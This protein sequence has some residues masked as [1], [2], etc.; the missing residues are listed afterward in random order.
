MSSDR[1]GAPERVGSDPT[2]TGALDGVRV[3]EATNGVAGS[4]AGML[5][6]DH[7]A[8]VLALRTAGRG[9]S[10]SE[11]GLH[12]WDRNKRAALLDP[13]A[14]GDLEALDPLVAAADIVLIGTTEPA[15]T[16][17]QLRDRGLSPGA[18]CWVVMPPYLLGETPW[19]GE[20]ESA[21][22]LFAGLGQAWSQASYD[23]RPVDCLYPL[24]LHMQ[25]VWAATVA[26]AT[27]V[28]ARAGRPVGHLAVVGGAHG[29]LLA[30]PG[31]FSVG[32]DDPHVHRPSGPGGALPNYRCY[33]CADGGWVFFGAFTTAFMQRGFAAI[34]AGPVLADPRVGGDP[35]NV[36]RPE[37]IGW[38]R[39]ELT[40]LFATRPRGE[41]LA[42]LEAADVPA[43]PALGSDQWLDHPQVRALGLRHE[44]RN[45]AGDDIVMPGLLVGLS[46]TPGSLRSPAP[47]RADRI[48][49]PSA[50][51]PV[52]AAPDGALDPAGGAEPA[53]SELPLLGL[54]VVD[55][56]TIIAGPYVATLLGELGA[57][58]D[59][60][61][62][63][64][65]GDE[66]RVAHGG[67]G[68]AGFS[69]YNRGQRSVLL[70]LT[71]AHERAAF[72]RII[73]GADVVV[74]NFRPDVAERLGI[75]FADLAEIN[76]RIS[77]VSISA[78]GDRGPLGR[79]P[80]F[81]P[82][83]QAM[84]GIMRSQGGPDE[85]D[86]PVF[87]S[88]P[89]ND[90]MSAALAAFGACASL[91]ARPR[92]GQGQHVT[93]TLCAAASLIQSDSL[94]RF[95][96]RPPAATG[97]RDFDGPGP[98]NRLYRCADGWVRLDAPVGDRADGVAGD[99]LGGGSADLASGRLAERI[100]AE[101]ATRSVARVLERCA[102][103]GLPAVAARQAPQLV[104]DESLIEHGVLEVTE[105]DQAGPLRVGP[106]FWVDF[107]GVTR[108]TPG[109]PPRLDEHGEA[110]WREVGGR[111]A[112][113]EADSR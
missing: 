16:Y 14:A 56:G 28:G 62:R 35:N 54:R 109:L 6:A 8:D 76:P 41:W 27:L 71:D 30:S 66:F 87:L 1:L 18:G 36:R 15:V 86:S 44:V 72:E 51:W 34:G 90:V 113:S 19:T 5:L 24:A 100:A 47:M 45:G 99:L 50:P 37:N 70:D 67:R 112:L 94:V 91:F 31:G 106:G 2:V 92:L 84:S 20:W 25:G 73:A 11:P 98:L 17:D 13:A 60:V 69:V 38:I 40:A 107:P 65:H 85:S 79:R 75:A 78:F 33:R 23:D 105:R 32:R 74:E 63:P 83:V 46:A 111:V 29:A 39:D 48:T 82:V 110:I 4:V 59:K 10:V 104:G 108:P 80:G 93:V 26:V 58:V 96:G 102:A 49:E 68:G 81:D 64:P 95:D 43:A 53:G 103:A 61:E 42:I 21:G 3:L 88:A 97:G 101:L 52:R 7:G 77:T 12:V 55:L 89:A 9:P 22:L 57:A